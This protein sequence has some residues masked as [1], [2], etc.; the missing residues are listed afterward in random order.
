MRQHRI[1]LFFCVRFGLFSRRLFI[2]TI[3]KCLFLVFWYTKR[4]V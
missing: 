2:E 4:L 1:V 3:I